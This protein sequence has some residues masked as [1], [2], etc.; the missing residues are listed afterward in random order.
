MKIEDQV[1]SLELAKQLKELGVNQDSY[2]VWFFPVYQKES[3]EW[4]IKPYTEVFN[5]DNN[6]PHVVS[7][8][9]V[10]ELGKL[11][12]GCITF[13]DKRYYLAASCDL[14]VYYQTMDIKEEIWPSTLDYE[15][16]ADSRAAMLI[17]LIENK[18]WVPNES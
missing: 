10:S 15:I 1:C 12:P 6:N 3:F 9:T 7:A 11:L 8:F 18:I 4:E 5:P 14:N 17:H 13:H 16:E 2:F